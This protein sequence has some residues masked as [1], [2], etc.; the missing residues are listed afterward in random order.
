MKSIYFDAASTVAMRPEAISAYCDVAGQFFANPSSSHLLGSQA[1]AVLEGARESVASVLGASPSQI[2]FNSGATE[3]ANT[4]VA[5]APKDAAIIVSPI[6]HHCVLDPAM[7]SNSLLMNVDRE[8]KVDLG[9]LKEIF[10]DRR[11]GIGMVFLMAVNNETGVI[12]PIDYVATLMKK[13]SPSAKLIVDAVQAANWLELRQLLHLAD[14]A[15]LAA[16]KFGGPKGFGILLKRGDGWLTPFIVGGGQEFDLRGGT[17]DPCA[18]LAAARALE[19]AQG[20]IEDHNENAT[21]MRQAILSQL[22][23]VKDDVLFCTDRAE[24]VPGILSMI[25]PGANSE[26]LLFLLDEAGLCASAGSACASG[27]LEP[28]HVLVSMGYTKAQA[29]SSLRLSFT[30]DEGEETAIIAGQ[31]VVDVIKRLVKA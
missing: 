4:F 12:Q 9:H 26:E 22:E 18:A 15:F 23:E 11:D 17:Q 21:V 29:R 8:G 30:G 24:T 2:I 27:A 25:V 13:Y 19:I 16:H 14:G 10:K 6:E 3:S 1:K 31:I 5:S 20:E 7:R 28:S